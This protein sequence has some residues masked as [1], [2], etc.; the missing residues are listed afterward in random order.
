MMKVIE[1]YESNKAT[2]VRRG[3][4]FPPFQIISPSWVPPLLRIYVC[5]YACMDVGRQ[6][7][8]QAGR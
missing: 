6:A 8:R 3:Y 4:L 5:M 7:G 1:A 2:I